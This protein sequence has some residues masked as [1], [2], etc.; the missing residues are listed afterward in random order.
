M[1]TK[2]ITIIIITI[3]LISIIII[4]II[5]NNFII[6]VIIRLPTN[7]VKKMINFKAFFAKNVNLLYKYKVTDIL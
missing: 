4:N 5:N 2:F 6:I 7:H 1:Q 3:L